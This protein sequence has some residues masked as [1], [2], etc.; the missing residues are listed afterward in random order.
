VVA[1]MSVTCL[2]QHPALVAKLQLTLN[3][4]KIPFSS[5][6]NNL[7]HWNTNEDRFASPVLDL[8]FNFEQSS[9]V[10]DLKTENE[11]LI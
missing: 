6:F 10:Q 3:T 4:E 2:S 8:T 7:V 5:N 1:L 11:S 9:S